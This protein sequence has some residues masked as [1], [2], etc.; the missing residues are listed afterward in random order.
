MS[1]DIRPAVGNN[2]TQLLCVDFHKYFCDIC[3][4]PRIITGPFSGLK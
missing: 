2:I 1:V 4:N 3:E